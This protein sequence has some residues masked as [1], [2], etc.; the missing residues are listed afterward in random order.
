MTNIYYLTVSV[1][2]EFVRSLDG[3]FWL[4]VSE[5]IALI[6]KFSQEQSV[7][8]QDISSVLLLAAGI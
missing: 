4:R 8:F 3:W 1:G 7:C 2:K 6:W 5:E